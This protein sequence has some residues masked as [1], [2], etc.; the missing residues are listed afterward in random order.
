M[1]KNS[2]NRIKYVEIW[3]FFLIIIIKSY[4]NSNTKWTK[5]IGGVGDDFAYAII[6]DSN[7]KL[8]IAG[9]TNS[10]IF[11]GKTS[12]GDEDA[13]ISNFNSSGD[14]FWTNIIGGTGIDRAKAITI[15]NLS[16]LYITGCT[17]SNIFDGQPL[18]GG[19]Y[20]YFILKFN[21]SGIKQL[22]MTGIGTIPGP[23]IFGTFIDF[24]CKYWYTDCL[25]QKVC[26]IYS[27]KDFSFTFGTL[28]VGFKFICWLSVFI[29][30]LSLRL[31]KRKSYGNDN[32]NSEKL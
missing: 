13:F 1:L 14:K 18:S 29:G 2:N 6:I 27:N 30:Y 8:Y 3:I 7:S 10:N 16:N 5:T 21:S 4:S 25:K 17:N 32:N 11:D 22:A 26:K 20:D 24:T 28:G 19:G 9:S 12:N 31:R 23:I 15:D